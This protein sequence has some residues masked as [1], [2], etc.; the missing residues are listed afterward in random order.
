MQPRITTSV[1]TAAAA[2]L[3]LPAVF[4]A[5]IM[6]GFDTEDDCAGG[7]GSYLG[8]EQEAII[9]ATIRTR[10]SG[11][12]YT[13]IN[14]GDGVGDIAS[15]AYQFVTTTWN[16][17][18]GYR[19]AYQAPPEVQDERARGYLSQALQASTQLGLDWT[20]VPVYWYQGHIPDNLDYV[21]SPGEGNTQTL[22]EYRNGWL[23]D[24]ERIANGEPLP[25]GDN[26]GCIGSIDGTPIDA[27]NGVALP[28][29]GQPRQQ[30]ASGHHDYG[31]IDIM[32]PQ[33]IPIYVVHGGTIT[34]ITTFN[35]NC[36]SVGGKCPATCGMGVTIRDA[37]WPDI[38]W[39]Y[40]HLSALA[41]DLVDGQAV[42]AGTQ[43][44]LSG[45]TGRSG[46]PHLH[47]EIRINNAKESRRCPQP[48]LLQIFDHPGTMLDPHALSTTGCF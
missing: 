43:L 4:I 2:I 46:A 21:P 48:L 38:T 14:R 8:A 16:N 44:G 27:P 25:G 18:G 39:T 24:Y 23:A 17:F 5:A 11:N 13:A 15:G 6:G 33:G 42:A 35:A 29:A 41:S 20:Y 19:D 40:C 26:V 3:V 10:E 9:L 28:L 7:A 22:A 45:N 32:I 30:F 1:A 47:L 12:N 37:T 34:N 36:N 31:A